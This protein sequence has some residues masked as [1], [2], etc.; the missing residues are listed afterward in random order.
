M[1]T[2]TK[3]PKVV[4]EELPSNPFAFEVFALAAKQKSNAKKVEVLQKYEHPSL[5]SLFIWNFDESI[6]SLLPEGLVPYASVGQQNVTAGNLSDNINRAV[7]MMGE[8]DS[9]SIGS[10]DQGRTSIRKEYTYFYNF[11]KGGNDRLSSMKRETM[12]ISIL[13]GLHPLEA[14]ILMLVKDKKL[15]TK[16][17][18]SKQVVSDAYPDIRW[19]DRS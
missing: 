10:Q 8:L 5:K 11:V 16:Y 2:Q 12:F 18:I 4:S 13:E 6:I 14:E 9:N 19:G 3:I 15:E 17:S 1:A 7:Q